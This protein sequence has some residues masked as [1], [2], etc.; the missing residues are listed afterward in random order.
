M[1]SGK[2]NEWVGTIS[3]EQLRSRRVAGGRQRRPARP[4]ARLLQQ[5]PR[6]NAG[7]SSRARG[8]GPAPGSEGRRGQG[9]PSAGAK[10][11]GSNRGPAGP[12]SMCRSRT[13]A[14]RVSVKK[15]PNSWCAH[16]DLEPEPQAG[17]KGYFID[18]LLQNSL[19]CWSWWRF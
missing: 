1:V 19:K 12:H 17:R 10:G 4:P 7:Q 11:M 9:C 18:R 15:R 6:P 3:R 5:N 13:E 14:R 16:G 2:G 8:E